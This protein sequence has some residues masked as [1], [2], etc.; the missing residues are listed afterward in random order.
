M[1]LER[2]FCQGVLVRPLLHEVNNSLAAILGCTQLF[3]ASGQEGKEESYDLRTIEQ[4][5]YR[6][7][8][9][10]HSFMNLFQLNPGVGGLL[11][12]NSLLNLL[13]HSLKDQPIFSHIE[14]IKEFLPSNLYFRGNLDRWRAILVGLLLKAGCSM[15]RGGLLRVS[16]SRKS[17]GIFET[18]IE[19]STAK[20]TEGM[21]TQPFIPFYS[22]GARVKDLAVY[23]AQRTVRQSGGSLKVKCL[24]TGWAISVSLPLQERK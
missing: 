21:V 16:T 10:V 6:L 7:R 23:L 5:V 3:L 11:E 18:T 14:L 22:P 4:E 13:L 15:Q 24:P 2:V 12:M 17:G 9:M 20:M 8:K 19:T 1:E